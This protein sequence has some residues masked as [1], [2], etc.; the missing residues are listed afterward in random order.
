MKFRL[1]NDGNA[2]CLRMEQYQEDELLKTPLE[3]G[4]EHLDWCQD[5]LG[6]RI[7]LEQDYEED[8]FL[9]L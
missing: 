8:L 4:L 6:V 7:V 5:L 1:S 9:A 3:E 2:S